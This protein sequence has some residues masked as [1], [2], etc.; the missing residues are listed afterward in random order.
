MSN[1]TEQ[2]N[3]AFLLHMH[4]LKAAA[5]CLAMPVVPTDRFHKRP[6][7]NDERRSMRARLRT[8]FARGK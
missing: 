1:N 8:M 7:G 6:D 3:E 5:M 4:G 2:R